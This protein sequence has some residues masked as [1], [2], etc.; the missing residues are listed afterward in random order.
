MSAGRRFS[1]VT[2]TLPLW[3]LLAVVFGLTYTQAPL[4]YS[5]QNQYFLHGLAQGGMGHLA[6][7]WLANTRDP[8]PFFTALIAVT[9]RLLPEWIFYVY[10]WL[11]LGVYCY[12]LA[13]LYVIVASGGRQ[14]PEG[15]LATEASMSLRGLTPPAR[16]GLLLF[17]FLFMLLHSGLVRWASGQTFGVDYP[18]YFQAGIAGQY[19][20]G[21]TFQPSTFGV[22]LVLAIVLFAAD[23]PLLAV[24][25]SSLGGVLHATYLLPAAMLTVA[26]MYVHWR[27]GRRRELLLTPVLA[28]AIVTPAVLLHFGNFAPTSA[29]QFAETQRLLARYRIPHHCDVDA[30]FDVIAGLQLAWIVLAIILVRGTRLFP[31]LVIPSLLAAVLSAVQ[32]ATD[33]DGLALLFPWRLSSVLV[34]VATAIILAR[35]VLLVAPRLAALANRP[36]VVVQGA[37]AVGML[38][39]AVSG[40]VI[41]LYGLGYRGSN[42]EA[43]MIAWVKENKAAGD[44]FLVPVELPKPSGKPGAS[45]SDFRP[46]SA[47]KRGTGLIP[48]ELQ[49][50]RL[51][52]GAPIVVDYKSIPYQDVEV[53]EWYERVQKNLRFYQQVAA[54]DPNMGKELF[55]AHRVTHVITRAQETLLWPG[56]TLVHEDPNYRIYRLDRSDQ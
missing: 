34:P 2:R 14:P 10:Y 24:T 42:D 29:E 33:S 4:Y 30:F 49:R 1:F 51:A 44:V 27:E 45:S 36:R 12:A 5:N 46:L 50:F 21:P 13:W 26:F 8:T 37:L 3:L 53:L 38:A 55:A 32:I 54:S 48:I 56:A 22:L 19:I 43:E 9:Y 31:V 25:V 39:L 7:D 23:R 15:Q 20:L 47:R 52:T 11:V 6:E 35:L 18:W 40:A 16:L 28:L 17:L 41:N